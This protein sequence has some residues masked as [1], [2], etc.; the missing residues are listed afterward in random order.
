MQCSLKQLTQLAPGDAVQRVAPGTSCQLRGMRRAGGLGCD[1]ST[2]LEAT[3][4]TALGTLA[5]ESRRSLTGP[6][7]AH[8]SDGRWPSHAA[9]A[10]AAILSAVAALCHTQQPS[11]IEIGGT[12]EYLQPGGLFPVSTTCRPRP[13]CSKSA[14]AAICHHICMHLKIVLSTLQVHEHSPGPPVPGPAGR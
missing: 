14:K 6:S 11:A 3:V 13:A 2:P 12:A 7:C 5:A 1:R 4:G 9:H 8:C 10:C